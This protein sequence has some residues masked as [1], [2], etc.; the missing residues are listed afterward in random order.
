[1]AHH[2]NPAHRV[3]L[4]IQVGDLAITE[5]VIWLGA[6]VSVAVGE[7]AAKQVEDKKAQEKKA[8]ARRTPAAKPAA[9]KPSP[10]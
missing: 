2:D 8:P 5:D 4:A 1:V 9:G 6:R 3:A 10:S 7:E